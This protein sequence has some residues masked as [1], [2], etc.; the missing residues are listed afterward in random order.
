MQL[1]NSEKSYGW[2]AILMHWSLAVLLIFLFALGWWM[3][4]LD[5][6]SEWYHRVP[7]IHKSVGI[8][9]IAAMLIR[10]FWNSSFIGTF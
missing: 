2:V 4:E 7:N 3:V 10:Y 6:Y 8:L 5:Y 9:V 1:I